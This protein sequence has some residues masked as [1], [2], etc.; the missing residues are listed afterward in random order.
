MLYFYFICWYQ[1]LSLI[2]YPS[3]SFVGAKIFDRKF[4]KYA[5][6]RYHISEHIFH[7]CKRWLWLLRNTRV[8]QLFL[9]RLAWNTWLLCTVLQSWSFCRL[10]LSTAPFH[11]VFSLFRFNICNFIYRTLLVYTFW[12]FWCMAFGESLFLKTTV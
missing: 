2:M 3:D 6:F 11:F 12:W 7:E 1:I 5:K 4:C 8:R 9:E 10:V